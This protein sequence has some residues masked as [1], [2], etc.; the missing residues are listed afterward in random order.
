MAKE[1][2]IINQGS[3]CIIASIPK[4]LNTNPPLDQKIVETLNLR[5]P[6]TVETPKP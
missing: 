1:G 4:T 5:N 3:I 6:K 2:H